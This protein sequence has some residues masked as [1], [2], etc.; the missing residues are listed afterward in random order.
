MQ[1]QGFPQRGSAYC[2]FGGGGGG[3]AE[4]GYRQERLAPEEHSAGNDRTRAT[5][6]S[7]RNPDQ[8]GAA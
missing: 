5:D 4:A 3:G 7:R 6:H 8:T 2:H 1:N